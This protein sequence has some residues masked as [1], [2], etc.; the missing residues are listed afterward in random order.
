MGAVNIGFTTGAMQGSFLT[1]YLSDINGCY[2]ATFFVIASFS[3]IGL[4]LA[5]AL[6]RQ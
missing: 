6:K 4:G 1:G 2:D 5:L 3:V